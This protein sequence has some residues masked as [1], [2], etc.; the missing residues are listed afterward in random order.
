[1]NIN[2]TTKGRGGA[3]PGSG[4]PRGAVTRLTATQIL[5]TA[6]SML[7]KPLI[8]SIMEGYIGAIHAGDTKDRIQYE[9]FLLDKT[10]STAIEA[11][12]ITGSSVDLEAKQAA[13]RAAIAN[14]TLVQ[15]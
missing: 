7:G 2:Q 10:T 15:K 8:Q 12:V 6:E 9:K 14:L 13:F 1:M 4:R 5:D 3:R 11:E